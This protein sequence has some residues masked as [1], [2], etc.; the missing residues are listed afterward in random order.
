MFIT[1]TWRAMGPGQDLVSPVCRNAEWG[2]V[3][4]FW[5]K[6]EGLGCPASTGMLMKQSPRVP[7]FCYVN[8]G[9]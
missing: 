4:S 7:V 6:S 5:M 1:T 8:G 2:H 9:C 3:R